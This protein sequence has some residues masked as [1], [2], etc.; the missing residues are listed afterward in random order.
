MGFCDLEL[1]VRLLSY[2]KDKDW[3]CVYSFHLANG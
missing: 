2:K 1:N 3:Y